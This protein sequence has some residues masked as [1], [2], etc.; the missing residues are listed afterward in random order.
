MKQTNFL[1]YIESE[2]RYSPHTLSAYRNDLDQF[3]SYIQ[4]QYKLDNEIDIKHTHIRSWIVNL[5]QEQITPR[6]I[7]RKLSCLKT[8]FKFLKKRGHIKTNPLLK[9][10]TPKVG[11]RLPVFIKKSSIEHLLNDIEFAGDY[12]GQRDKNILELFYSTGM[13]RSEL[14]NLKIENIDFHQRQ[15][16]VLGKGNKERLIPFGKFLS[17]AL[18]DY[19]NVREAS[20]PNHSNSYLFLTPKG[21][22]LYPKLV[23][24]VVHK[25]LSYVTTEDKKSP[26]ILRHSFATH[27][28]NNGADLNAIKELLGHSS[29]A[30]T[31]V[32][33]HN[34][35][36]Q[37]KKVYQQAHPKANR[38]D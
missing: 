19:M 4:I 21:A 28:S 12:I 6:S 2:K 24:N 34:S 26:H 11:K 35:I 29:L 13:R 32:Y 1:N 37:L 31:Q 5:I 9:V 38:S 33:T 36:E 22:K 3:F 30:A 15:L 20:F 8:Y 14:I 17:E 16:K 25:Y 10:L 27:L 23:Y 7:N 18:Q